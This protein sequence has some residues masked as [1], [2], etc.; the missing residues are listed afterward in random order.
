MS[1]TLYSKLP[2]YDDD[3]HWNPSPRKMYPDIC[4]NGYPSILDAKIM[5]EVARIPSGFLCSAFTAHL[6]YGHL[7]ARVYIVRRIKDI[8]ELANLIAIED[9]KTIKQAIIERIKTLRDLDKN[10][11]KHWEVSYD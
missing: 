5:R 9:D 10:M 4:E 8:R 2:S 3:L 7:F 1:R 11:R 6:D